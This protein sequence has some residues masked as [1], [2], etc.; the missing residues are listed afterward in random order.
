MAASTR[1]AGADAHRAK[2]PAGKIGSARDAAS[3]EIAVE[4][5]TSSVP[6]HSATNS[7]GSSPT[8]T[9]RRR[10]SRPTRALFFFGGFALSRVAGG[11]A[12][13]Y[14]RSGRRFSPAA[15]VYERGSPSFLALFFWTERASADPA[16]SPR[17]VS[18]V[19]LLNSAR[20]RELRGRANVRAEWRRFY[21]SPGCSSPSVRSG[22]APPRRT[23]DLRRHDTCGRRRRRG[24]KKYAAGRRREE[25]H[26][27]PRRTDIYLRRRGARML[28]APL[29]ANQPRSPRRSRCRRRS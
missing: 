20:A 4:K 7:S 6:V 24:E 14:T 1:S 9:Y 23:G 5:D 26:R 19:R 22:N 8:A 13:L 17:F 3:R 21:G 15:R 11:F 18:D 16:R 28:T 27:S 29:P 12:S 10:P 2:V 25:N